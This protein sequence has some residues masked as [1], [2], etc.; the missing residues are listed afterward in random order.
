MRRLIIAADLADERADA[1]AGAELVL[2]IPTTPTGYMT[3]YE[4]SQA[5]CQAFE[6]MK[7]VLTKVSDPATPSDKVAEGLSVLAHLV[8]EGQTIYERNMMFLGR[9]GAIMAGVTIRKAETLQ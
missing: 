9:I 8:K 7:S 5:V 2:A 3:F 4:E 1:F 6:L